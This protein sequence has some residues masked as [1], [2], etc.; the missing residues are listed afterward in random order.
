MHRGQACRRNDGLQHWPE[1]FLAAEA[2]QILA[3]FVSKRKSGLCPSPSRTGPL[4][5]SAFAINSVRDYVRGSFEGNHWIMHPSGFASSARSLRLKYPRFLL[6]FESLRAAL[7]FGE[8]EVAIMQLTTLCQTAKT[9]IKIED[10][11][12]FLD[13]FLMHLEVVDTEASC[14][15]VLIPWHR[16]FMKYLYKM[17][18]RVRWPAHPWT[19]TTRLLL[20]AGY[21]A[22]AKE[23]I[24]RI[25][26]IML[27]CFAEIKGPEN[28]G[29]LR[30]RLLFAM[31]NGDEGEQLRRTM[32]SSIRDLNLKH[33]IAGCEQA[34]PLQVTA[35][36]AKRTDLGLFVQ[37]LMDEE[38]NR[39]CRSSGRMLIFK[40]AYRGASAA[41]DWA[42]AA[43]IVDEGIMPVYHHYYG[44]DD[45][46]QD[47]WAWLLRLEEAFRRSNQLERA[48]KAK[49]DRARLTER[50]KVKVAEKDRSHDQKWQQRCPNLEA[51]L[52]ET[53]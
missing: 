4:E 33:H 23:M 45:A 17:A 47:Q 25:A 30:L 24:L 36:A 39:T 10:P 9:A 13:L 42:E 34:M 22:D 44:P 43:T 20:G 8:V 52:G 26:R 46:S 6:P 32:Q 31:Y 53:E 28:P 35:R 21:S 27:T 48:Y 41:Y 5:T 50:M 40:W 11:V 12:C 7:S 14:Q 2:S 18:K 3:A 38:H 29:H 19:T 1:A 51:I 49:A 37:T 15:A 16:Y